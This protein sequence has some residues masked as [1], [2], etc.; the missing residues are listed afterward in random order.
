M[1]TATPSEGE[2]YAISFADKDGPVVDDTYANG[3]RVAVFENGQALKPADVKKLQ[4]E[5]ADV[6]ET[7]V[8]SS[9]GKTTGPV[10][11]VEVNGTPGY[12]VDYEFT[13][14]GEQLVGRSYTLIKGKGE[15]H[16]SLQA[17]AGD[18]DSLKGTLEEA[19]QT[20]TLD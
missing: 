20:F 5:F 17:M 8:A 2:A 3:L 16:L 7:M 9:G 6:I 13:Q 11:A 19:A 1:V 15:Y 10:T 4:K 14:G 12:V 18:W